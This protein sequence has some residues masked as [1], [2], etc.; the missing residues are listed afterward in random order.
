MTHKICQVL[1]SCVTKV[2]AICEVLHE[3]ADNL[4]IL[5]MKLRIWLT[6]GPT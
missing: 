2:A 1:I 3:C 5:N 4:N 6:Q